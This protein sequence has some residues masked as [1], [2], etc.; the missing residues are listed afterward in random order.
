MKTILPAD[1][2]NYIKDLERRIRLLEV[3]PQLSNGAAKGIT[4]TYMDNDGA[5]RVMIGLQ[6]DGTYG[7]RVFSNVGAVIFEKVN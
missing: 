6:S 7:I 1:I 3:R 2:V 5:I 4:H